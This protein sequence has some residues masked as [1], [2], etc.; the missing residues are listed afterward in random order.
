M[1]SGLAGLV[2]VVGTFTLLNLPDGV[3]IVAAQQRQCNIFPWESVLKQ[4]IPRCNTWI[5]IVINVILFY[6]ANA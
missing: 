6:T 1:S 3:G 5:V 2:P 4:D